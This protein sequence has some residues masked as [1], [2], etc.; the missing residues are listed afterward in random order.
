MRAAPSRGDSF[1]AASLPLADEPAL[2]TTAR[3]GGAGARE[4]LIEAY[5]PFARMLAAKVFA[6]RIDSDLEFN[7]YLQFGTIGLIE[8]VD[9]FDPARGNQFK[10][11]AAHRITGAILNGIDNMSEKRTQVSTR[12]RMQ[13]ERRE[14][15]RDT[16]DDGTKDVFQQLAEVAIGLALGYVLDDPVV[17]HHA[18][19]LMPEHQYASLEMDQLRGKM[20][21]LVA[22]LP[23]RERMVIKYHYLN[24]V[25]FSTVAETMG[26]TKGR[27]SQIHSNALF[28]LR[29]AANA[30]K[31]C[32]VAW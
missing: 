4:G 2:W 24:Q 13:A 7:E 10:T 6:G 22:A 29:R 27:V 3:S 23:Q 12:R 18:D 21:A 26:L 8:A 30:V 14:S 31:S 25:P 11:F 28:L 16:L 32:D 19:A 9:R 15:A 1:A 17:Y 20:Q 5:L